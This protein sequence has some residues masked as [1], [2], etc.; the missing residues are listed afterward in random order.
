MTSSH[1]T[2]AQVK[3]RSLTERECAHHKDAASLGAGGGDEREEGV[4][5]QC[6]APQGHEPASVSVLQSM[7]VASNAAL[8]GHVKVLEQGGKKLRYVSI[9]ANHLMTSGTAGVNK[10]DGLHAYLRSRQWP[11]VVVLTEI[12]G[13]LGHESNLIEWFKTRTPAVAEVYE[14]HWSNRTQA[15]D[16]SVS[17]SGHTAGGG[18]AI[19]WRK[20][21]R[22]QSPREERAALPGE[23]QREL[24][25]HLLCLRFDPRADAVKR[26]RF[27][28]DSP[29]LRPLVVVAAY[30]PPLGPWADKVAGPVLQALELL[31]PRTLEWRRAQGVHVLVMG[32]WNAAVG[33]APL[34]L[35]FEFRDRH[36]QLLSQ[37]QPLPLTSADVS[38]SSGVGKLFRRA[39][40]VVFVSSQCRSMESKADLRGARLLEIMRAAALVPVQ[41]IFS[42]HPT[43]FTR[44]EKC[45]GAKSSVADGRR[46]NCGKMKLRRC[47]ELAFTHSENAVLAL[48]DRQHGCEVLSLSVQRINWPQLTLRGGTAVLVHG[49]Q[50]SVDHA[51]SG[52]HVWIPDARGR[53]VDERHAA[54]RQAVQARRQLPRLRLTTHIQNRTVQRKAVGKALSESA[55]VTATIQQL[56]AMSSG[57]SL[58]ARVTE[59]DREITKAAREAMQSVLENDEKALTELRGADEYRRFESREARKLRKLRADRVALEAMLNWRS[60]PQCAQRHRKL[61]RKIA[62]AHVESRRLRKACDAARLLITSATD[63]AG[64][65]DVIRKAIVDPGTAAPSGCKLLEHI[66]CSKTGEVVATNPQDIQERLVDA[67]QAAFRIHNNLA[68]SCVLNLAASIEALRLFGLQVRDVYRELDEH[69]AAVAMGSNPLQSLPEGPLRERLQSLGVDVKSVAVAKAEATIAKG[70]TVKRKFAAEYDS[71]QSEFTAEELA[72]VLSKLESKGAGVDGGPPEALRCAE[73]VARDELLRLL[74]LILTRGITPATWEITRLVMHYKGKGADPHAIANYRPLGIGALV[75]KVMALIINRRLQKWTE[76]TKAL[77]ASQCGFRPLYGTTE[78]IFSLVES[79]REAAR[80]DDLR[81]IYIL[82]VDIE[83]AYTSVNHA[84]L[85]DVLIGLGI[86]GRILSTLISMYTGASLTLDV[87]GTLVGLTDAKPRHDLTGLLAGGVLIER[88]VLQGHATSPILFNLYINSVINDL[89]LMGEERV[90]HGLSPLGVPVPAVAQQQP[91]WCAGRVN[92]SAASLPANTFSCVNCDFPITWQDL[93]KGHM[94]SRS[95]K[96]MTGKRR[97]EMAQGLPSRF[98]V[99]DPVPQVQPVALSRQQCDYNVSGWY[100]DDGAAMAREHQTMQDVLD[101]IVVKLASLGLVLNAGKTKV[102][103]VPPLRWTEEQ[104]REL[105]AQTVAKGF[106]VHRAGKADAPVEVVDEFTYLGVCLWWRWDWTRAWQ[107]ARARAWKAFHM[108]QDGGLASASMSMQHMLQTTRSLVFSHLD[109]VAQLSGSISADDMKKN[110]QLENAVLRLIAG[111]S[112]LNS[113]ASEA[114]R[115]EAG[116]WD[117]ETR[118]QMLMLR[119][120]CKLAASAVDS[121]PRRVMGL[122]HGVLSRDVQARN[123]PHLLYLALPRFQSW[124]QSLL[125]AAR[126]FEAQPAD[127]ISDVGCT[128][129]EAALFQARPSENLVSVVC[130]SVQDGALSF[131]QVARHQSSNQPLSVRSVHPGARAKNYATGE[132]ETMWHYD[133]GTTVEQAWMQ[134]SP[135]LR[136]A[137]HVSLRER[138]N[139]VRQRK[140]CQ[141]LA[142]WSNGGSSMRDYAQWKSSSYL[143]P[144]WFSA[145]IEGAR[146]LLLARIDQWG[147]EASFRRAPHKEFQNIKRHEDRACY[148]CERDSWMPET[149]EHLALHC[150]HPRVV[151]LR[152]RIRAALAEV[153]AQAPLMEELPRPDVSDDAVFF[154][155][156]QCCTGV[157]DFA[158]RLPPAPPGAD[159]EVRRR[160]PE[161]AITADGAGGGLAHVRRS[162]QW[163][164]YWSGIWTRDPLDRGEESSTGQ[165][166][167]ATVCD[168]WHSLRKLRARLL[169]RGK[170]GFAD[171]ARDPLTVR[172]LRVQMRKRFRQTSARKRLEKEA[173]N[174]AKRTAA[175]ERRRAVAAERA[176]QLGAAKPRRAPA[177][178][179]SIRAPK[180]KATRSRAAGARRTHPPP[181]GAAKMR[182]APR[183]GARKPRAV[184]TAVGCSERATSEPQQR[185]SS[186]RSAR[187]R[188]VAHVSL[189]GEGLA[190]GTYVL[191]I[192]L[193]GPP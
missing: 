141:L 140:V 107:H 161:L 180:A 3:E 66:T 142:D 182:A 82:F 177:A 157:G 51:V 89:D 129:F 29:L 69:C 135:P 80:G 24:N 187:G 192:G 33:Q 110:E 68:D 67:W 112:G 100:A 93:A 5:E 133:E 4:E 137:Q 76:K 146:Q 84:Q 1:S 62:F 54:G 37:L 102:M 61:T 159:L 169:R 94:K 59:A 164:S 154:S 173:A 10:F 9:N 12:T 150:A 16:G 64:L 39:D 56:C 44:C 109:I 81:P 117:Q 145:D 48:L 87:N 77:H 27:G 74:N 163:A 83:A 183:G 155:L 153:S 106:V 152:A 128:S 6:P 113:P 148:L 58:L 115:M 50:T 96:I 28:R 181:A 139:R 18:V 114:L 11:D 25:G 138:G 186:R 53:H 47:H 21:L 160:S 97:K 99:V 36:A 178:R 168:F 179:S 123:D 116:L 124:S 17:L 78:A 41:G 2:D 7:R 31:M 26:A 63:K 126:A 92:P 122:V 95:C 131:W 32:H 165:A 71:L 188:L 98:A 79:I 121:L 132:M 105:K 104:Y 130:T 147:N 85:W 151:Q 70:D 190:L 19:M 120:A 75:E 136:Q 143:E 119:F 88:G 108:L 176:A 43:S 170:S 35:E 49:R 45:P 111:C 171:R 149:L 52:G 15:R 60:D 90:Q 38:N 134:W 158:H 103:V 191:A 101:R 34:D 73:Q 72:E 118:A 174:R 8:D 46:C 20:S 127:V 91:Q 23:V 57:K 175:D 13:K 144:Y 162:A 42:R 184:T 65:W 166:L 55:A 125:I 14:M 193:P 156:L 30:I 167:I 86:D 185:S 40:R 189:Q 172:Q 22:L